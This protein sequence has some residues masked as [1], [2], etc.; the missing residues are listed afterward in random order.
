VI[1]SLD[2]KCP[3]WR[4]RADAREICTG[5][6]NSE[7]MARFVFYHYGRTEVRI[8]TEGTLGMRMAIREDGYGTSLWNE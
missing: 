1:F 4:R 5:G 6:G 3:P 2:A 7:A 8:L